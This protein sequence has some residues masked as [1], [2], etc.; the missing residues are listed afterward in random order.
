M[1]CRWIL[2]AR[3]CNKALGKINE[4]INEERELKAKAAKLRR[5]INSMVRERSA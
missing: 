4:L 5:N 2:D 1:Y 3:P